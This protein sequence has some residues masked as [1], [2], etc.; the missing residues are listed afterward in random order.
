MFIVRH[1]PLER[2]RTLSVFDPIL[3]QVIAVYRYISIGKGLRYHN[4]GTIKNTT[5][6]PRFKNNNK[7]AVTYLQ[8][9]P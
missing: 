1:R 6:T 3:N 5:A 4:R 7:T 8:Q 2:C 9:V